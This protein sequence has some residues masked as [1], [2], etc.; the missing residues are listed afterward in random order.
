MSNVFLL[1]ATN[2]SNQG[3]PYL[4]TSCLAIGYNEAPVA[5]SNFSTGIVIELLVPKI[6]WSEI[7][8]LAKICQNTGPT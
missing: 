8:G 7:I 3:W 6:F 5:N 1:T 4:S 2:I